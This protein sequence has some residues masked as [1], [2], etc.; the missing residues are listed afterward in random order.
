MQQFNPDMRLQE[1]NRPADRRRRPPQPARRSGQAALVERG[2]EHF[3]RIDAVH[4]LF[5]LTVE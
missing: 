5:R 2:N 3:H 1:G 4:R